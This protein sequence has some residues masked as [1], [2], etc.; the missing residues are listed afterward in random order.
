M[1]RIKK[2]QSF[3]PYK[4]LRQPIQ[5]TRK[6]LRSSYRCSALWYLW[7]NNSPTYWHLE[8]PFS[9]IS[10]QPER[11]SMVLSL[12]EI[13][14]KSER[15][16]SCRGLQSFFQTIFQFFSAFILIDKYLRVI[17]QLQRC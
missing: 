12:S 17:F 14:I 15:N 6:G 5:L 3:G 8:S 2:K 16:I 1:V 11:S 7:K 13:P 9:V 4:G 10:N